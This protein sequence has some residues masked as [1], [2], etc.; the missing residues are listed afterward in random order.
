MAA[1]LTAAMALS[2]VLSPQYFL[3]LLPVLLA[4]PT[5]RD[6]V[7][8]IANWLLIAT[9]YILTGLIFPWWY[10]DLVALKPAAEFMLILRNE[11]LL[12]LA[13]SLGWRAWTWTR[14]P[15]ALESGE[16]PHLRA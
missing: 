14:R 6:K 13:V 8:S 12:G 7:A 10:E 4:L 1:V 11:L 16:T 15:A 2:K 3:F 9:I 5:P